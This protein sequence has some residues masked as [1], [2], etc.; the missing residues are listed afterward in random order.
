MMRIGLLGAGPW[1][2]MT[3]APAL[4]AH[5]DV[6]FVG[7]WGRR[8]EVAA[9]LAERHGTRPYPTPGELFGDVD[10]VAM[11]VEDARDV[12]DALAAT[13]A[14]SVVFLT[15]RFTEEPDRWISEQASVGG[16]FSARTVWMG[17]LD[18][19]DNP[20]ARSPWRRGRNASLWDVGPH[21]LS[22]LLPVLGDVTQVAALASGPG[23]TVQLLTQHTSGASSAAMLSLTAPQGAAGVGVEV[24][25]TAGVATMPPNEERPDVLLRRAIDALVDAASTGRPHACDAAFGLRI[26]EILAAAERSLL[27][28][29]WESTP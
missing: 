28:D 6:E 25:G 10:A 12:T 20:F 16:W 29:R 15:T 1:A 19:G 8:G 22:V 9:A 13:H 14:T 23:D 7:I 11:S 3:H 21:A 27:A 24:R 5:D 4:A 2:E 18:S 17:A 26:V